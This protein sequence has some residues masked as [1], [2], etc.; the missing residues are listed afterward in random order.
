MNTSSI[1]M[2]VS[3]IDSTLIWRGHLPPQNR[4]A[5]ATAHQRGI[6]VVLATVRKYSSAKKSPISSILPAP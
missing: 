1:R 6:H 3:D 2:I 4:V 5:L